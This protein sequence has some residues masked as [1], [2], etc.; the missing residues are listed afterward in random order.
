MASADRVVLASL[1][2]V[3]GVAA[4]VSGRPVD[5][6]VVTRAAERHRGLREWLVR[7]AF[8]RPE[9]DRGTTRPQMGAERFLS[10]LVARGVLL[11]APSRERAADHLRGAGRAA[12]E[13]LER[14]VARV[15]A[16]FTAP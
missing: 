4:Q 16:W 12:V 6:P 14:L 9:N 15:R 8:A 11:P 1:D 2:P 7:R 10:R 13:D 5:W 3:L